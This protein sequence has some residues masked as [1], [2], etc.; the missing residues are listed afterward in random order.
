MVLGVCAC[1]VMIVTVFVKC[2]SIFSCMVTVV[3]FFPKW[4]P[5]VFK[6]SSVKCG[7]FGFKMKIMIGCSFETAYFSLKK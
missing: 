6:V 7:T 2:L 3:S 5:L 1:V 4:F